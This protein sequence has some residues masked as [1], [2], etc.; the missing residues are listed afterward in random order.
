MSTIVTRVGKGSPLTWTEVDSNFTNLNTD[1]L[2]SGDTAASLTITSATINGGTITGI[3]DLAVADGGTGLSS[4]TAGYIPFGAGTS[5]FGSSANL[6]WDSANNRLGVGTASPASLFAVDNGTITTQR[7]GT[8]GAIVLRS[9]N[10]TQASPTVISSATQIGQMVGRGYDGSAYQNVGV[11]TF[12]SE[13]AISSLSSPGFIQF[14]TTSSGSVSSTEKM[15]IDSTGNVGIGTTNPGQKLDIVG[16]GNVFSRVRNASGIVDVIALSTGDG[17][18]V[19]STSGKSLIF[20]SSNTERMRI[21]S[22]GNVGIGTTSPST[23]GSATRRVLSLN[24]TDNVLTLGSYYESGIGQF[25]FI[26]SSNAAGSGNVDLVFSTGS[27]TERMR[28][29]SA[30]NVGIGTTSPSTYGGASN[31]KLAVVGGNAMFANGLKAGTNAAMY[32]STTDASNQMQLVFQQNTNANYSIQSVEQGVGF[33]DISLQPSGGNVGI[34]TTSPVTKLDIAATSNPRIRFEDTGDFEWRIGIVD[35]SSFGFFSAGTV[36]E[37]MRIDSS[38]N[39]GIGTTSPTCVLDVVGGIQTSRTAVTSPAATD[40]NVF[41]GTYTPSLNNTTNVA[42]STAA[43]CQYMR[44]GNVVTVSGTVT[45]DP[46]ATGRIVMGFSLPIASAIAG[47]NEVGGTFASSG[48]TTV[49]V[50]SVTGDATNDRAT[51]DGI[52]NDAA[53]RVYGF[54]FTYRIL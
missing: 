45:I 18:V 12:S 8:T 44:V 52:A 7:Y 13:G 26:N 3:T 50:G 32:L 54:S 6:F 47:A 25:S 39:V 28:I 1:K 5:A 22:S 49:N 21:D 53:S 17:Y 36:T 48:T 35:G 9:A 40:G 43:V 30:G 15:R 34:G 23:Y 41:S 20:G 46:T 37:R 33:K 19:A 10:G 42:S 51:F 11:I 29:T 24:N 27:N 38:G 2:Q 14:S 4:L 31:N 16:S